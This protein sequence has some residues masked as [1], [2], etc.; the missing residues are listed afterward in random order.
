MLANPGLIPVYYG[1]GTPI[2]NT[3]GSPVFVDALGNPKFQ[4]DPVIDHTTQARI[5]AKGWVC[6]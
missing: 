5:N 4:A 1:P 6:T 2:V 3:D